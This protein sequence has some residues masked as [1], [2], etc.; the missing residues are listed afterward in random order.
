MASLEKDVTDDAF[1]A[2]IDGFTN[3]LRKDHF[4]G[5]ATGTW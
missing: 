4:Y 2:D 3:A 1:E 5:G